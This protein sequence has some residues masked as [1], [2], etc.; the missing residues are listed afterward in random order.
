MKLRVLNN[1]Y[2]SAGV[3]P[4]S[5]FNKCIV[6]LSSLVFVCYMSLGSRTSQFKSEH[7]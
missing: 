7:D 6:P 2:F 4:M 5:N 3:L 1:N